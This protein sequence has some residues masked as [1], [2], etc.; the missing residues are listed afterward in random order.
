M[1]EITCEVVEIKHLAKLEN[2]DFL[3]LTHVY[4]Y[5]C[6]VKAGTF[7]VGDKAV[8][9]PVDA[10]LPD[11]PV[12]RFVWK[13]KENP[14]DKERT[15]RAIRL[16]GTFSMGL[17]L[18]FDEVMEAYPEL[19]PDDW[20]IGH[21]MA[22]AL[23]VEKYEPPEPVFT[24]GENERSPGWFP[25]YTDI[26]NLRKYHPVFR[27]GEEVV[28]TEK[29]HGSNARFAYHEDRLWIGSHH[30]VKKL[31]QDS[32]PTIW[33]L[34]AD[35]LNLAERLSAFPGLVFFGEVYGQVQKGFDYGVPPGTSDLILFDIYDISR[36]RYLDYDDFLKVAKKAELPVVP[37]LY[38]GPW[39]GFNEQVEAIAD[40]TST[41]ANHIREGFVLR[42][43]KERFDDKLGRV[44]LKLPGQDYLTGKK[45][46][47]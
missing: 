6:I 30:N 19:N 33:N 38:R 39:Q 16:R 36:G 20:Q 24:G 22:A 3:E 26:E 23:G 47:G 13:N 42:P 11:K 4:S 27:E 31:V 7:K 32:K 35:K 46:K 44:I 15:I 37:E 25:H 40:G 14:T 17:C 10:K 1:S 29:I 2:S 18:P 28:L 5:P 21:N 34:V 8:Y 43:V 9:F 45:R 12:F 41:L